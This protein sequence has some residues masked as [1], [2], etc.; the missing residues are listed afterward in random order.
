MASRAR[1]PEYG[2]RDDYEDAPP[3]RRATASQYT[4]R[5]EM[6]ELK[7]RTSKTTSKAPAKPK[8]PAKKAAP[9][10]KR[11]RVTLQMDCAG[12]SGPAFRGLMTVLWAA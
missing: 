4:T 3:P 2:R 10:T 12:T 9:A 7:K 11:R 1:T 6:A 8:A 5:K